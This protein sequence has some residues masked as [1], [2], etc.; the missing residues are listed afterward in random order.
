VGAEGLKGR[1]ASTLKG[2]FAVG[3]KTGVNFM[4]VEDS[5]ANVVI[6]GQKT[7]QG[8]NWPN[9]EV[10]LHLNRLFPLLHI[11]LRFVFYSDAIFNAQ[12]RQLAVAEFA[13]CYSTHLT[14]FF[15]FLGIE[16]FEFCHFC[17]PPLMAAAL[18]P[19]IDPL[20]LKTAN[21]RLGFQL[22]G[23]II[24]KRAPTEAGG[25]LR[26]RRCGYRKRTSA[27]FII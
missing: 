5:F 13:R 6:L 20:G 11:L 16:Q 3:P 9:G 19:P 10:G 22:D 18:P 14:E 15:G 27:R 12:S 26:V 8:R 1:W 21:Q 23:I 2:S 7:T 17:N 25:R 4:L 24:R